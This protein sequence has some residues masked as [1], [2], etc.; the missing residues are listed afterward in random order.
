[1]PTLQLFLYKELL[2]LQKEPRAKDIHLIVVET[3]TNDI[4]DI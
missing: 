3:K 2:P 1:M 4:Q